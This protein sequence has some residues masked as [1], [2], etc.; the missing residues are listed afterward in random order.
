[1]RERGRAKGGY[2]SLSPVLLKPKATRLL[3]PSIEKRAS[4]PATWM[5]F[6]SA[7]A[8]LW[9]WLSL[10]VSAWLIWKCAQFYAAYL[11]EQLER[12][13]S[14]LSESRQ[15]FLKRQG[16]NWPRSGAEHLPQLV[17]LQSRRSACTRRWH[18]TAL[19]KTKVNPGWPSCAPSHQLTID[20]HYPG[21]FR[22]SFFDFR[23]TN[24]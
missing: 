23:I 15:F 22:R 2:L 1:M 11:S 9:R 10:P 12:K 21:L 18:K 3:S 5:N 13:W 24:Y 7:A 19:A 4:R 8:E 17:W 20:Q 16:R 6:W 14:R